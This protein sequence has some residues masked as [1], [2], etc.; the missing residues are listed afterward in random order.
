M[1]A[2]MT[3]VLDSQWR[4][5]TT[6]LVIAAAVGLVACGQPDGGQKNPDGW[7]LTDGGHQDAGTDGGGQ[8]NE[9]YETTFRLKNASKG[10]IRV[11]KVQGCR[12]NPPGWFSLSSP[13]GGIDYVDGGCGKCDCEEVAKTGKCEPCLR[14]A[15]CPAPTIAEVAPGSSVQ[16]KWSGMLYDNDTVNGHSCERARTPAEGT[17]FTAEFCW[18]EGVGQPKPGSILQNPTCKKVTFEYGKKTVVEHEVTGDVAKPEPTEFVLKNGLK[19]DVTIQA[20]NH[21]Q[22]SGNAWVTMRDGQTRV[23]FRTDCTVCKCQDIRTGG[24]A[25]CEKAC[26]PQMTEKL[27]AGAE[28]RF[29]WD[30]VGYRAKSVNAMQC[31]EKWMPSKDDELTVRFCW[32]TSGST[33]NQLRQECETK[34]FEYG[35]GTVRHV[36]DPKKQPKDAD[37]ILKNESGSPIRVQQIENC[38]PNPPAWLDVQQGG[39]S[40]K[41]ATSCAECSCESVEQNGRCAVCDLACAAPSV[42]EVKSGDL[43]KWNWPGYVYEQAKVQNHSCVR[44]KRP[45]HHEPFEVEFCWSDKKGSTG[46]NQMLSN[47]TCKTRQF[48]VYGRDGQIVH[49]IK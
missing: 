48:L 47:E 41:V 1:Q 9:T 7:T 19:E 21:C 20:L 45:K 38:R 6:I 13:S 30:G 27:A 35:A 11:Q 37:I 17:K 16:W 46:S 12:A 3:K 24:C 34:T 4:M 2:T 36:I 31:H 44:K 26:P 18:K 39:Q 42:K 5:A 33:G 43:V 23:D 28:K 49:T 15:V 8:A 25:V 40:V 29:R 32:K 14:P 10:T 22:P